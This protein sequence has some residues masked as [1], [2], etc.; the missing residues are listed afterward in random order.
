MDNNESL[1]E[2]ND[3]NES[4]EE[5]VIDKTEDVVLEASSAPLSVP[6]GKCILGGAY[7]FVELFTLAG[8]IIL[9]LFTFFFRLSIVDGG[10]MEKTLHNGDRILV[11]D[12][13][14]TPRVGDIVVVQCPTAL[15][16]SYASG[17]LQTHKA[18]DP[19]IK[20]IVAVAGD[21]VEVRDYG[22]VYVNGVLSDESYVYEDYVNQ[23]YPEYKITVPD[24]MVFVAGDHR[25]ASFDG[26]IFGPVDIRCIQGRAFLRISP[27]FGRI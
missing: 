22:K 15:K 16:G 7:D 21:E 17:Y 10:S 20:R 6:I 19:L 2:N 5:I 3:S 25:N 11:S 1:F 18:G 8:A 24:G 14:Y 4:S 27:V 9:I 23:D 12:T 13:F 26:R